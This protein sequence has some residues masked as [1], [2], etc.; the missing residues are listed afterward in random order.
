MVETTGE[1]IGGGK[2][3]IGSRQLYH[4]EEHIHTPFN[5]YARRT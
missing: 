3:R 4:S 5:M 2:V 1:E